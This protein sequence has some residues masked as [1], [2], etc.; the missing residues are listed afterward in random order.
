MTAPRRGRRRRG[1]CMRNALRNARLERRPGR[2]HQRARHLDAARRHRRDRSRSSAAR[3]P[4]GEGRGQLDQVDDRPP[5]R[6]RRRRR[7]GVHGARGAATRSRRRR[8]TCATRIRS[9]TSTT[10]RTRRARCRS[11]SRCP[12]RSASA[13]P[14]ARWSSAAF[15]P[16]LTLRPRLE[17]SPSLALARPSSSARTCRGRRLLPWRCCP[18]GPGAALAAALA[19]A[20]RGA[21]LG[22][23]AAARRGARPAAIRAASGRSRRGCG[24][25]GGRL[26]AAG[27]VAGGACQPRWWVTLRAAR[28]GEA[29]PAGR[30][31]TCS[32]AEAFRAAAAS[33]RCGG[34]LAGVAAGRGNWPPEPQPAVLPPNYFKVRVSV[35]HRRCRR[36]SSGGSTA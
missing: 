26:T 13:A 9:A 32:A 34:E 24:R 12:T 18:A 27:R 16:Q 25:A 31:R 4:R 3:R 15:E 29:H 28:A 22:P 17:L 1:R 5:A 8:S 14:T 36:T 35:A 21:R 20:G 33:G 19:A 11:A 23:R 7:G 2:L 10:C 6:R 30:R